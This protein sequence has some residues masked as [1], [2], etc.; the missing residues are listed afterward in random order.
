[1]TKRAAFK[2]QKIREGLDV[3]SYRIANGTRV[4]MVVQGPPGWFWQEPDLT[5]SEVG[6]RSPTAAAV[7]WLARVEDAPA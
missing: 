4:A 2:M 3:G 1:M 7:D 6:F 5:S